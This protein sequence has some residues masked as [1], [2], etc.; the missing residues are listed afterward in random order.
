MGHVQC[1]VMTETNLVVQFKVSDLDVPGSN[2][3]IHLLHIELTGFEQV[4]EG[5]PESK[6][7]ESFLDTRGKR[8]VNGRQSR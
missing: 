4:S 5:L 2:L 8:E 6:G 7:D 1:D 3:G